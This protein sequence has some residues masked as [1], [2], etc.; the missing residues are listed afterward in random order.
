[1]PRSRATLTPNT[2]PETD[3]V[4]AVNELIARGKTTAAEVHALATG[5]SSRIADLRREI[6]VLERGGAN[7]AAVVR[8]GPGRP[9][10]RVA[11]APA[12]KPVAKPTTKPK[13]AFTMTPK[14]LAARKRQGQYIGL[15]NKLKGTDR[16]KVKAIA[17]NDGVAKAIGLAEKMVG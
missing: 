2:I 3:L 17:K 12:A 14:A 15:L 6:A 11:V 13:R 1:M 4:Y 10:K 8:R 5:R 16:A 7:G 9:P